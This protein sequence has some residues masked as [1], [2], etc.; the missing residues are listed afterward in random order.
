MGLGFFWG[1]GIWVSQRVGL[2]SDPTYPDSLAVI[3][4]PKVTLWK[5]TN[6]SG[7]HIYCNGKLQK[8]MLK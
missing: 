5:K 6:T 8:E 1:N 4:Y 7:F 2:G 3:L